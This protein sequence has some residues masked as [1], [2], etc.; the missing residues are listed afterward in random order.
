M[1]RNITICATDLT[2]I[3][4]H[5]PYKS[6]DE[7]ILK[8]WQRYYKSDY[9]EFVESLKVK[10]IKIKKEETDYEVVTRISKENNVYLG[11]KLSKCFKS[12]DVSDLNTNKESIIKSLESKLSGENKEKF[13][14]SL[15]SLTNTNFGIKYESKGGELYEEKTNNKIIKTSKY[16]KTELFQIPNEYNMLDTWGIGGKID[17]ILLPEN[18]IIEIKNRVKNL[19]YKLRGYEKIQCFVYMFLL[20]SKATD[21]VEV[22]K[23]KNDN[24]INI[25]RVDFNE[26]FWE[27]EI[28]LRLEDF[29]SDFYNFM[30]DPKR[31]LKLLTI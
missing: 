11:Q 4:G 22:L 27:K 14:K 9:L 16:Y 3:T 31:K 20:E 28:M 29:I 7:I 18:I 25:I 2:V 15:N 26:S 17:G 10:N 19:F 5:N 1:D 30:E 23:D 21:L 13:N 6:I 12:E 24:S 8:F